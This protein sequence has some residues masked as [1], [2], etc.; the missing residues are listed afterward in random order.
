MT[1]SLWQDEIV[2]MQQKKKKTNMAG[3]LFIFELSSSCLVLRGVRSKF[4][5]YVE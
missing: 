3:M 2:E 5:I 4:F 1:L